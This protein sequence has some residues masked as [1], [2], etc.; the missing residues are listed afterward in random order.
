MVTNRGKCHRE[1]KKRTEDKPRLW[2]PR[3]QVLTMVWLE[4]EVN[5]GPQEGFPDLCSKQGTDCAAV[6][7]PNPPKPPALSK[8][9]DHHKGTNTSQVSSLMK[10]RFPPANFVTMVW[11]TGHTALGC[12]VEWNPPPLPAPVDALT[13]ERHQPVFQGR[14]VAFPTPTRLPA[15]I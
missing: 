2:L 14:F 6:L 13:I 10:T 1:R 9:R 12:P 4:A 8:R 15:L 7:I 3:T 5:M 11:V